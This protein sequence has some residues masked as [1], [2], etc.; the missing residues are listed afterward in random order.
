[1]FFVHARRPSRSPE[2]SDF[3]RRCLDKHV[4]NR[5]NA[6]QLLQVPFHDFFTQLPDSLHTAPAPVP[7]RLN[8]KVIILGSPPHP[9]VEPAVQ[10]VSS[11]VLDAI[12]GVRNCTMCPGK[13]DNSSLCASADVSRT[14]FSF[15]IGFKVLSKSEPLT[16]RQP[17]RTH[18]RTH[19]QE[20]VQPKD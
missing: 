11:A 18:S 12:C 2:F 5:W 17:V 1:M 15:S 14:G 7:G 3:L 16:D 9:K 4:D 13:T 20:T 6:T 8:L 10:S 19:T